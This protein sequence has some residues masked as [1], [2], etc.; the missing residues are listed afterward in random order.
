MSKSLLWTTAV[1]IVFAFAAMMVFFWI[2]DGSLQAAGASVDS[3]LGKAGSEVSS[4]TGSVVDAAGGAIDRATD[5][6]KRT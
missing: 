2:R 3:L 1:F 6:D 4:T 5:G